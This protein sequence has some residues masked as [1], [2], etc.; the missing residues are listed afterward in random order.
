MALIDR[1]L[2]QTVKPLQ[3]STGGFGGGHGQWSHIAA[4]YACVLSLATVG[5][6]EALQLVD[7][8]AMYVPVRL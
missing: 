3:N 6:E 4:S 8:K 2:V 5:G 7:R 1:R